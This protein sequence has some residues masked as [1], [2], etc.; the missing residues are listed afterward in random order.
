MSEPAVAACIDSLRARAVPGGGFAARP[1]SG[2]RADATAWA[3]IALTAAGRFPDLMKI[4]AAR[5]AQDQ[6]PDGRLCISPDHP[7]AFW[8]TPLAVL[9]WCRSEAQPEARSRAVRFLLGTTGKQFPRRPDA[10]V[11]HDPNIKGWPWIQGTHSW[12]G[13]TGIT[14]MALQAAGAGT[15]DR[16]SE[17]VR[18]LMDRQ[19]RTGGWNY[20][21]KI[22]FGAELRPMPES[23]GMALSALT[24]RTTKES[25]HASLDY[26]KSALAALR[27]P[28]SLGWS[29]MGLGAWEEAPPAGRSFLTACLERQE[30]YGAYDTI[31]LSLLLLALVSPR[32]L[33]AGFGGSR[34]LSRA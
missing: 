24:N 30:R 8:P 27:T 14:I 13:S 34:G 17:G 21:N 2:Y 12:V 32:G 26:L 22:V 25:L 1:D 18:L 28:Y 20:G 33:A 4:S 19:L 15:D 11:A 29:L 7:E 6:L 3:V 10:P 5:L 23:T 31:S 16:V 9:A